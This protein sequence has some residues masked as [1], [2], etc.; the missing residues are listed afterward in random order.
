MFAV[1]EKDRLHTA[2]AAIKSIKWSNF[3][4]GTSETYKYTERIEEVTADY[5]D[6]NGVVQSYLIS[7][8]YFV[9]RSG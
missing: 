1:I 2:T 6:D 9:S 7:D 8:V 5:D 4:Q 3:Y